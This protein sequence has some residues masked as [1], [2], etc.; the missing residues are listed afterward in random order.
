MKSLVLFGFFLALA[1][2]NKDASTTTT[3]ASTALVAP[4]KATATSSP[5]T[6]TTTTT[7]AATG[8]TEYDLSTV[9][10]KW[11]GWTVKGPEGAQVMGD[12]GTRARVAGKSF[13]FNLNQD[14]PDLA[15]HRKLLEGFKSPDTKF[16]FTK[17][18]PDELEWNIE[19]NGHTSYSFIHVIHV[20]KQTVQCEPE[21]AGPESEL[22]V[23]A[24]ACTT[25]AKK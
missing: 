15:G 21:N 20:G 5:A 13:D 22:K 25:V 11:K 3:S 18:T 14:K 1:A 19:S 4:A 16:T 24:D 2:C 12:L 6:T 10:A 8:V 9:N 17:Q 7:A 23:I